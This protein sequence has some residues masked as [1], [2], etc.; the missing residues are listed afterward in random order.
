MLSQQKL[1][2]FIEFRGSV[3]LL[4]VLCLS[5][6][7][8]LSGAIAQDPTTWIQ[9]FPTY[10]PS[11]RYQHAAAF[12]IAN[13]KVVIFG[14]YDHALE[15]DTFTWDGTNWTQI[16][17]VG[18]SARI[19]HSMTY[20]SGRN[21]VVLF[22]GVSTGGAQ[23]DTWEFDGA[24][25]ALRTPVHK[26]PARDSAAL[27]Y[28]SARGRVVLF[29]GFKGGASPNLGDTWEWD[30]NDW[31]QMT[32]AT[33]PSPRNGHAM[34]YDP[35]RHLTVLFGGFDT[36]REGDT[37]T[38]DGATWTQ[39][40]T[41]IS[42]SVRNYHSLVFDSLK[43][44]VVL[45]G[46]LEKT[47]PSDVYRN[48]TWE[49]LGSDWN[50]L[51]PTFDP[52]A[53]ANHSAVYDT[54]RQ[55][56]LLF[57][58]SG[59]VGALTYL[60]D[61]QAFSEFRTPPPTPTPNGTATATPTPVV[62]ST[63]TPIPSTTPT[64]PNSTTPTVT[65]TP[66]STNTPTITPTPTASP[67]LTSTPTASITPTVTPTST[68]TPDPLATATPTATHTP[69]P[70]ATATP[71]VT[72]TPDPL[73]TATPTA[74]STPDPFATPSPTPTTGVSTVGT[75]TPMPTATKKPFGEPGSIETIKLSGLVTSAGIGVPGIYVSAGLIGS[76]ISDSLGRFSFDI[77]I[78]QKFRIIPSRTGFVLLPGSFSD[79]ATADEKIV[80]DA[81]SD[82]MALN[83]CKSRD[84]TTL[85]LALDSAL[86]DLYSYING[87]GTSAQ[88][89]GRAS[90]DKQVSSVRAS[91]EAALRK[92][93]AIPEVFYTCPDTEGCIR[94]D[95]KRALGGIKKSLDRLQKT[96]AAVE[97][98]AAP[99]NGRGSAK[100]VKSSPLLRKKLNSIRRALGQIPGVT[101]LCR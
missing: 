74:T 99:K 55:E 94:A 34:V 54:V 89:G 3:R 66:T 57:G 88:A 36:T 23:Q 80:I 77:A 25:W 33:S 86:V 61:T 46:G 44:R 1:A 85:K 2:R 76:R 8:S 31:T 14:G 101:F 100:G 50:Q 10:S 37:W 65:P 11:A 72:H 42:P 68:D 19:K 29:G 91:T 28:D 92:S 83:T 79:V 4:T 30:G 81:Y 5:V 64:V 90:L 78:D 43:N 96:A 38:Y 18:P 48:D 84:V 35:V 45:F 97:R 71:T 13:G 75:Q 95:I 40:L 51:H 9:L 32:P 69:D 7:F 52:T 26:P 93:L 20:D 70:L 24:T 67:T 16:A 56:V 12:D 60:G 63:A 62:P 73:A 49:L 59:G 17:V 82:P 6:L 98:L 22:G 21:R 27:A 53:R 15:G 58:G 41:T 47:S 87:L 39:V